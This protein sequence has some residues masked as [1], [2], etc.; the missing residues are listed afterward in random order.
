MASE[1]M[2]CL[3]D[4]WR[5]SKQ[6]NDHTNQE[7]GHDGQIQ[8][9]SDTRMDTYVKIGAKSIQGTVLPCLKARTEEQ[10]MH[11]FPEDGEEGE[12]KKNGSLN[13]H[14]L[15]NQTSS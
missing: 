1:G 9:P 10:I 13:A 8:N 2:S 6:T 4:W 7:T 11:R 15:K 5:R 12:E 14:I 3:E